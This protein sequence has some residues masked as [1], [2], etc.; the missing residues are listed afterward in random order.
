MNLKPQIIMK[1]G[2]EEYVVL[3]YKEYLKIQDAL[4]DYEDLIDLRKAKSQTV[5]EQT[6]S[7]NEVKEQI[8]K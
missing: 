3:S 5:N 8:L 7:F 6:V 4:E 1:N 2:K